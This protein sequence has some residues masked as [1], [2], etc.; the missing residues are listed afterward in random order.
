M[1]KSVFKKL[2][3]AVMIV[4]MA[5]MLLAACANNDA[6]DPG[7]DAAAGD[8]ETATDPDPVTDDDDED[9]DDGGADTA[10]VPTGEARRITTALQASAVQV[11]RD[12]D[13][14]Y[15]NLWTR[16]IKE[17]LNIDVEV[18]FTADASTDAYMNQMNLLLAT[19]DLPDVLRWGSREWFREAQEAGLLMDI[20]DV[21]MENASPEVL[22][23][24]ERYPDSFEGVSVDGR[25]YGFPFMNNNFHQVSY[26]WI[27]DDWLEYAGG[28]P[29]ET[30]EEMVAMARLF[31]N[32]DPNGDGS[33]VFGL[34]LGDDVIRGNYGSI[35][36]LIAAFGVPNLDSNGIFYRGD[37][38][39]ITFS[40]IQPEVRYALEIVH[41]LFV[42]GVIDPEFMV[43]DIPTLETDFALGRIGMTYH[44]N[45]GTW[46]P[47]PGVRNEFGVITRP[48]PIPRMEGFPVRQGI[49]NNSLGD[50]FVISADAEHPEAIIEIINLYYEVAVSGTQEQFMTYWADEQYRLAPIFIGIPT[51]NFAPE[52]IAALEVGSSEG[53]VGQPLSLFDFVVGFEDGSMADDANA[54]GTWGQMFEFGS[55]RIALDHLEAGEIVQ[56]VMAADVPPTW[57]QNSSILVDHTRTNFVHFVTGQRSLDEFDDF[58]EEW[59]NM[60]GQQVL[61]EM[62]ELYPLR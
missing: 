19:G 24:M 18:I 27:R 61:D 62:N 23:F 30:V 7:A 58:V 57:L 6:P 13:S 22:A 56:E 12:G 52:V 25:M 46:H 32:G 51:E 54:F 9:T 60:G 17:R 41:E 20:T 16:L 45:W 28:N 8:T 36:G 53:L 42:E 38:G 14:F 11:F 1:K 43:K 4:S 44:R 55:M 59:L 3:V 40:Y 34:A 35:G 26:L 21:F 5:T 37:D 33:S 29:P 31:A 49:R 2:L 50:F 15:D 47:F 10:D 39:L 48:Y